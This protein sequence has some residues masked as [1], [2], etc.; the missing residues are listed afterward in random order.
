ML[1]AADTVECQISDAAL[2]EL[3]G[4]KGTESIARQAQFLALRDA[5]ERIASD[6]FDKVPV[7]KGRVIRIFTRDI[8][9]EPP[10][11]ASIAPASSA[12]DQTDTLVPSTDA[13]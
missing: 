9:T 7:V 10:A 4:V 12:R 5:V 6:M 13:H 8:P 11:D 2:D 1:N 3:G